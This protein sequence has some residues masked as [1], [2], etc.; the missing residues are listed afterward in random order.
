MYNIVLISMVQQSDSVIHAYFLF[1]IFPIIIYHRISNTIPY[2]H[3]TVQSD[4]YHHYSIR[5]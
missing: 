1:H 5:V 2:S 4:L 3:F